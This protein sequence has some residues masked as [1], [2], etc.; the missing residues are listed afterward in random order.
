[1][2]CLPQRL[3]FLTA[4][5]SIPPPSSVSRIL[6]LTL[7]IVPFRAMASPT[8]RDQFLRQ[9]EQIVEGIKQSRMKVRGL[10]FC[11]A[12]GI[13]AWFQKRSWEEQVSSACLENVLPVLKTHLQCPQRACP[14]CLRPCSGQCQLHRLVI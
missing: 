6:F 8:A 1:M 7:L 12:A 3:E 2:S 10:V 5:A 4:S 9:M 13:P 14:A 11:N